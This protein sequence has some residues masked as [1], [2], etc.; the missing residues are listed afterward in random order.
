MPKPSPARPRAGSRLGIA[1]SRARRSQTSRSSSS[2]VPR[3]RQQPMTPYDRA[4]C[5]IAARSGPS[6]ITTHCDVRHLR[7]HERERPHQ[8][9]VALVAL[10]HARDRHERGPLTGQR[11]GVGRHLDPVRDHLDAPARTGAPHEP[12]GVGADRDRDIRVLGGEARQPR[13]DADLFGVEVLRRAHARAVQHSCGRRRHRVHAENCAWTG[14]Q[15]GGDRA[16]VEQPDPRRVR[17]PRR[18][19]PPH[20]RTAASPGAVALCLPAAS[21]A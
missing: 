2:T 8:H 12:R 5:S 10:L 9:V 19:D 3:K 18:P 16:R 1:S 15:P 13:P 4:I 21:A 11:R 14:P 6:P 17:Q 20:A 7:P